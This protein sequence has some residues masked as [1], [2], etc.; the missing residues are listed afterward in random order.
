VTVTAV[1]QPLAAHHGADDLF[2]RGITPRPSGADTTDSS[3]IGAPTSPGVRARDPPAPPT[4]RDLGVWAAGGGGGSPPVESD[5]MVTRQSPRG[6]VSARALAPPPAPYG[7]EATA[8]A[9]SATMA[10]KRSGSSR[11]GQ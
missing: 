6:A 7:R 11:N 1:D 4:R 3:A 10:L 5:A 9:K 8:F 2:G